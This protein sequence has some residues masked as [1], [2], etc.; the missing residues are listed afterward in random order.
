MHAQL[1]SEGPAVNCKTVQRYMREMGLEA[2][3]PGPNL[4][5]SDHQH[6]ICPYLLR[7]LALTQPLQVFGTGKLIARPPD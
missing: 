3:Y 1:V 6:Q 2:I 5:K 7:G 4:P